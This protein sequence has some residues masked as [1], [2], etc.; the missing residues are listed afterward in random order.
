[1]SAMTISL[2]DCS[3]LRLVDW[4]TSNPMRDVYK[5][6]VPVMGLTYDTGRETGFRRWPIVEQKP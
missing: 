4:L 6:E 5:A 2:I 3:D 1:M